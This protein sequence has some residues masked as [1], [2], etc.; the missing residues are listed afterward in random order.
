MNPESIQIV[1]EDE[2]LIA[3]NKPA[4]LI[5]HP[6]GKTKEPSLTEWL[7]KTYPETNSVGGSSVL[8]SGGEVQRNGLL[9][10]IDR[11][12]SGLIL[13]ARNQPAFDFF[14]KQFIDRKVKK[15][16]QAFVMGTFKEKEGTIAEKI[17]R[18]RKD[19]R[20]WATGKNT[21]G[22]LRDAET[23]FKCLLS[24]KGF[25]F[26][27]LSPKT[28]RTHQLRVHLEAVGFPIVCD[29]LYGPPDGC[30]LGF[31]RLALHASAIQIH[32]LDGRETILKAPYPEDFQ[33][34]VEMISI[35]DR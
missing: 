28:G 2:N 32:L 22:R 17:G 23:N 9:H 27:E 24:A 14:Q 3:V 35:K 31:S 8:A 34:A 33:R 19:F 10:R 7:A 6:D 5:V 15:V 21:R 18:N 1:Y 13:V 30:G 4:G 20:K 26:L 16:Y 12:T 29:K 11:E 25:S